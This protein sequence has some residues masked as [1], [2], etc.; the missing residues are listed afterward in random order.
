MS[1]VDCQKA[2]VKDFLHSQKLT[3]NQRNLAA[4]KDML[5]VTKV[6]GNTSNQQLSQM[7]NEVIS[8]KAMR[9]AKRAH[10]SANVQESV[11]D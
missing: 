6:K 1:V 9:V 3:S 4:L 11:Q 2:I 8:G 7:V 5:H 10:S